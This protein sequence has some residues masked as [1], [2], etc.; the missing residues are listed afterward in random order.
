M[1]I[2]RAMILSLRN[3]SNIIRAMHRCAFNRTRFLLHVLFVLGISATTSLA[4]YANDKGSVDL[5]CGHTTAMISCREFSD[6][7]CSDSSVSFEF[8]NKKIASKIPKLKS[9]FE[10]PFVAVALSCIKNS[11]AS[12]LS[13]IYEAGT[14]S[15]QYCQKKKYF[16]FGDH[17]ISR[18]D[19]ERKLSIKTNSISTTF[20]SLRVEQ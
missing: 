5:T 7:A 11:H 17:E 18:K 9:P 20:E 8:N 15:S 13:I 1:E 3:R 14:C 2:Y 6:G 19:A 16:D 12:I 10:S 4:A